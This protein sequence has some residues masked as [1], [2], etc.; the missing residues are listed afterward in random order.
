MNNATLIT[1]FYTAF[2]AHDYTRMA[3]CYHRDV[4]FSDPAFGTLQGDAARAMWEMLIERSEGKLKLVFS[5]VTEN[6]AHWEAHYVFT[7]TGRNVHNKI[8][9]RFEFKDGKIYRHYDHFNLWAW[10][11]QA[12]GLSGLLLG[13]TSY[14]RKKLQQ[15]TRKLLASYMQSSK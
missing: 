7:K 5:D 3:A 8:D 1:E 9:A 2:A 4:E 15:Q 12:L 14:F 6:S 11:R 10:S 13:Y